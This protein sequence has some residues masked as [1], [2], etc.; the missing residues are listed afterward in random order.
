MIAQ[1]AVMFYRN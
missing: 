1:T